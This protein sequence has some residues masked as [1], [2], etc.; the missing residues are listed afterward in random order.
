MSESRKEY[1]R[2]FAIEYR[3]KHP[4]QNMYHNAKQRAKKQNVPFELTKEYLSS[5][6]TDTCPILGIQLEFAGSST[7]YN[8][9]SLDRLIPELG[10]VEGNVYIIS[11]KANAIKNNASPEELR[12]VA[13]WYEDLLTKTVG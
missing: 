4:L 13:Q 11:N 3:K 2:R 9:P 8:S 6:M 5:I 7:R 12:K 1:Q 10:Y